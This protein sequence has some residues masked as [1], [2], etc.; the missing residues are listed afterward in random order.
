M[1]QHTTQRPRI[2]RRAM[3]LGAAALIP[4]AAARRACAQTPVPTIAYGLTSKT[5]NDWVN[6]LSDKLGFFAANG[7]HLD[8]INVGAAA[9]NAQQLTS[10]SLN[11]AG[12]ASPNLIQA[13]IGG[14]P[15][16]AVLERNT[17]SPYDIV[18]KKGYNSIKDLKGKTIIVDSPSGITRMMVDGVLAAN[19]MKS[20]DVTYT[21][22]GG[23]PERFAALV[24][25]AVDAAMLLPPFSTR[26]MALGNPSV[27]YIPKY[28]PTLPVDLTV[29]NA[30]WVKAN[31]EVLTAFLRAYL[32]GV[33]WIYDPKNRAQAVS[34]LSETTNTPADDAGKAY[35]VYVVKKVFSANGITPEPGM[36]RVLAMLA[37]LGQIPKDYPPAS[38]FI[39]NR[40]VEA[41]A[42]AKNRA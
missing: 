11:L 28:F 34:I 16:V 24:A 39:D 3:L 42:R 15:L 2:P 25:G 41:A 20:E 30:N 18:A 9:A 29:A 33:R 5:A 14:A 6:F 37:D 32:Q 36:G 27:A 8:Y 40:F 4:L 1:P 38:K 13:V 7:I 22:S 17:G 23:T 12:V 21:Y 19:K 35:D 10:G 26:A 31:P